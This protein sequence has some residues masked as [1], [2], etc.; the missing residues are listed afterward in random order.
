MYKYIKTII[1]VGNILP[2]TLQ[3]FIIIMYQFKICKVVG[4]IL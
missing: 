4:K 3:I 2:A 1:I